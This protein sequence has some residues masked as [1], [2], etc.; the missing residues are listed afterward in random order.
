MLEIKYGY[1]AIEVLKHYKEILS[2][3]E[4]FIISEYVN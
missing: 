4:V 2:H 3:K 1:Q